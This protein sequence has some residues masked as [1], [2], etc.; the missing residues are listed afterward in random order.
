MK[1]IWFFLCFGLI[2]AGC[3]LSPQTVMIDPDFVMDQ[4]FAGKKTASLGIEVIDSRQGEVVGNRGGVYKSSSHISTK[5]DITGPIQQRLSRAYG[6]IGYQVITGGDKAD[7]RL[8]VEIA[9]LKYTAFGENIVR[10]IETSAE[11]RFIC[12]KGSKTFT[13]SYQGSRKQDV[14]KAPTDDENERLING[15]LVTVFQKMLE[16]RELLAFI[17][18]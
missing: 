18:G 6:D 9:D 10:S 13:G 8:Q 1:R 15:A 12:Q 4:K 3:A 7:A 14:I 16:D 2:L 17:D 5:G 11:I